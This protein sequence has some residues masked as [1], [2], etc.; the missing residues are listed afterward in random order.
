ML[1]EEHKQITS[2]RRSPEDEQQL[3]CMGCGVGGGELPLT[4][5]EHAMKQVDGWGRLGSGRARREF[6]PRQLMETAAI[7]RKHLP[8]PVLALGSAVGGGCEQTPC[9]GVVW[10]GR[11]PM[12]LAAG[13]GMVPPVGVP[14]VGMASSV[15]PTCDNPMHRSGLI[16]RQV[17][18][19]LPSCS[20]H[21]VFGWLVLPFILL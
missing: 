15:G 21:F 13:W 8:F 19:C 16:H 11:S 20:I 6:K 3:G 10:S 9:S 2:R 5:G 7:F 1:S 18:L 17:R 12:P 14:P 4:I